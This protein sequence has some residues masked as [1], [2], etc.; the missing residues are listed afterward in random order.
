LSELDSTVPYGYCHCGCGQK[1]AIAK[2][3][4]KRDSTTKG[5]PYRYLRG[6]ISRKSPHQYIEED[7][8]YETPCWIWQGATR[9]S[10]GGLYG[11]KWFRDKLRPAHHYFYEQKYGE[12]EPGIKMDHLC[13][14]TLCVNSDHLEPTSNAL[15]IQRGSLSKLTEVEVKVILK[16][17]SEGSSKTEL[18]TLFHVSLSTVSAIAAGRSWRNIERPQPLP[19]RQTVQHDLKLQRRPPHPSQE[20]PVGYCRCGCGQKTELAIKTQKR[21]GHIKG[22]P[23]RYIHGHNSYRMD[24]LYLEE[25]RGYKTRCW[26]WCRAF[27]TQGYAQLRVQGKDV[28]AHRFLYQEK[29][30]SI[31]PGLELHHMCSEPKCVNPEHMQPLD[32]ATHSRTRRSTKLTAE[33]CR[34]MYSLYHDG[35]SSYKQLAKLFGVS[36]MA[37]YN[38]VLWAEEL[39]R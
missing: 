6:H 30:G 9:P 29:F 35:H 20:I 13:Q 22:Q 34:Q 3:T 18:A 12:L 10:N 26:I 38:A 16:R 2:K 19:R 36:T 7:R 21:N 27:N 33:D 28:L 14:Q 1:T 15:N 37:A 8:G 5:E 4:S 23:L 11:T 32:T 25:D 24:P 31:Y 39:R 17:L